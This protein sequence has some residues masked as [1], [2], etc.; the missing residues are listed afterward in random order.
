[1]K[2]SL[3]SRI[4]AL[5][6]VALGSALAP[7]LSTGEWNRFRGP[8]GSGV[9]GSE[10][11]PA[12]FGPDANVDWITEVPFGRSSPIVGDDHVFLTAEV[13]GELTT[14]AIERD[15]GRIA[16]R[17]TLPK[18]HPAE[19]YHDND[20]ATPTPVTDG[21][22]VYAFFQEA[23]LVSYDPAGRA[24]WQLDLGEMRNFYGVAASPI[25]VDDLI[26]VV[27]DQVVGSFVV[28][29]DA[30]SGAVRWRHER[31]GRIE[32]Y[33]TPILYPNEERPEWILVLGSGWI[34]A[35]E[36]SSGELRWSNTGVGVGPVASPTL[37]GDL[38]VVS[39]PDHAAEPLAPFDDLLRER[40][41]DG[42]GHLVPGELEGIW[43]ENHFG[44]LDLDADGRIS[45]AD[46]TVLE[47]EMT[48]DSWGVYGLQLGPAGGPPAPLWN[49]RRSVPYIPTPLL[50]DGSLYLV[51]DSILSR[52]D[53]TT[54]TVLERQRLGSGRGA[55][56]ASPVA[57]DGKIF[58]ATLD[59]TI[60]VLSAGDEPVTLAINEI[61]NPIHAT[62]AIDEGKLYVRTSDRLYRF[63]SPAPDPTD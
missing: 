54:G 13:E 23:G 14:L 33:A 28:G 39:A 30:A 27:A 58:V 4:T 8:N 32:S 34:D 5:L 59:G 45:R 18:L 56:Y 17:R 42:D 40:D 10:A 20:S 53:P 48:S 15:T 61:G 47:G 55:V 12:E 19:L 6:L 37:A 24:R 57:A 1:M 26:V 49:L 50:Y 2:G 62:P 11:L 21:R 9:A 16:W 38:L 29:V 41:A 51:K 3:L 43:M 60:V 35:Y 63:S 46:W 52:L 25:L 7:P 31:P 22:N 44:F 36:I